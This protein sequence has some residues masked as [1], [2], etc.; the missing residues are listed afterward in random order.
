MTA[1]G[2]PELF[3]GARLRECHLPF[4]SGA[5]SLLV[6]QDPLALAEAE[7][8][9]D[10]YW[11]ELWPAS[12]ALAEGLLS[13]DMWLP[14]GP[15]PVLELG[16]GAGLASIAAARAGAGGLEVLATDREQRALALTDLNAGRNGVAAC[17]RT[18]RL[19]WCEP[20]DGKHR[21]ILAADCLYAPGAAQPLLSFLR[22][23]LVS[24]PHAEARAILVD[25]DRWSARDFHYQ[26]QEAGFAVRKLRRSVPFT[27]GA[28]AKALLPLS[29]PPSDADSRGDQPLEVSFYEL[30][31]R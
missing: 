12:I 22:R 23:A 3:P 7:P 28:E 14:N 1:E 25:P 8:D 26:A 18:A 6:L 16:C 21:L 5:L 9:T 11:G 2:L 17:V 15:E 4:G 30:M 31:R 24:D 20:Y 13:G 27:A 19:D 10:I 29:G